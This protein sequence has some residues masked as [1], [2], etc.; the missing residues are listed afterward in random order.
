MEADDATIAK[1]QINQLTNTE[2]VSM[3]YKEHALCREEFVMN[4]L[5]TEV[6]TF[7]AINEVFY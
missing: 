3:A 5:F 2:E 1:N 4:N 6:V 7:S